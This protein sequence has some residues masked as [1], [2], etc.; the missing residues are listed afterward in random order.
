MRDDSATCIQRPWKKDVVTLQST[1]NTSDTG[2]RQGASWERHRVCI[3][4]DILLLDPQGPSDALIFSLG[5]WGNQP[6][7][8]APVSREETVCTH[9][10]G[11]AGQRE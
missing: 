10:L 8:K 3:A 6:A 5:L 1:H 2:T 9:A 11:D 7:G 4:N